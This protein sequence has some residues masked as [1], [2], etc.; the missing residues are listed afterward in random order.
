MILHLLWPLANLALDSSSSD[1]SSSIGHLEILIYTQARLQPLCRFRV[2]IDFLLGR[3]SSRLLLALANL[4]LS[5]ILS[6]L[7]GSI[8]RLRVSV[9]TRELL[10][11]LQ[12]FRMAVVS[13]IL[14]LECQ[15]Q[16]I[17]AF[18]WSYYSAGGHYYYCAKIIIIALILIAFL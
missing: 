7:S 2:L 11:P 15:N 16:A 10:Q 6:D 9:C 3:L 13:F 1:L 18:K 5:Q 12:G 14:S 4:A 17:S 8:A